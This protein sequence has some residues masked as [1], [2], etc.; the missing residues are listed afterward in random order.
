MT[1]SERLFQ[2]MD[3]QGLSQ[4]E[5]S[6][7][8]GITQ[9]TISDWKRKKTNPSADKLMVI[10]DVLGVSPYE[11]L[12]DSYDITHNAVRDY[13][14]ITQGTDSY[15]LLLDF[16]GLTPQNKERVLGYISALKG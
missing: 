13:R 8:T 3:A 11:L 6:R 5:F 2:I 15:N 1:I 12:Q 7:R 16:E 4:M 10:C 14:I 9:S